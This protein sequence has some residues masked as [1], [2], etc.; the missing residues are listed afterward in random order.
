[1]SELTL[2][3]KQKLVQRLN[4]ALLNPEQLAG[5]TL[6]EIKAITLPYGIETTNVGAIFDVS[7]KPGDT[8]YFERCTN[9][10]D[11]IGAGMTSGTLIIKG[12]TGHYLGRG[13]NGGHIEVRGQVGN[14]CGAGMVSGHIEIQGDAGDGLGAI[15]PGDP[16]GMKGGVILVSGS[17]GQRPGD[18]MRRGMI[19]ILGDAGAFVG[20]NMFAGTIMVLGETGRYTGFGMKRGT[21]ILASPLAEP[22]STFNDC[23]YFELNFLRL[24]FNQ[25]SALSRRFKSVQDYDTSVQRLAGDLAGAGRGE[26][27]ILQSA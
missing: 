21:I 17:V 4:V 25:L 24:V 11:S 3:L 9:K 26:I 12:A 2:T 18:R 7:G 16:H 5:K 6:K 10:I 14:W 8:I 20:T 22:L 23:G 15:Y 13:L 27:L 1:M 19:A